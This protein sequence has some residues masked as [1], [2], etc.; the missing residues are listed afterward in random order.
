MNWTS[1][2]SFF[3]LFGVC[4]NVLSCLLDEKAA[5]DDIDDEI[6]NVNNVVHMNNHRLHETRTAK[7]KSNEEEEMDK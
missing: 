4:K 5:E 2:R 6:E 1:C 3:F 7:N